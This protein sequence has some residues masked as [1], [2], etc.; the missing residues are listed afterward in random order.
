[1]RDTAGSA[2]APAAR[3]RKV[4]RGSFIV[5]NPSSTASLDH[6]VGSREQRG[7]HLKAE[8]LGGAQ[9]DHRFVLCRMLHRKITRVRSAQNAIDIGSRTAKNIREARSI[10]RA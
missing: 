1:M 7:R 10:M 4:L 2:A 6:R 5:A 9:V 3:R 8:R